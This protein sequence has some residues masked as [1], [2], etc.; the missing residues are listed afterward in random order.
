MDITLCSV[1]IDDWQV[2]SSYTLLQPHKNWLHLI[3]R[4]PSLV[5]C[6][7]IS[8]QT[9]VWKI[10]LIL[11]NNKP[12]SVSE[13]I[14]GKNKRCA[15]VNQS[16]FKIDKIFI[17]FLTFF[18]RFQR[19]QQSRGSDRELTVLCKHLKITAKKLENDFVV[20][21]RYGK[22]LIMMTW[23]SNGCDFV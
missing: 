2:H 6:S 5:V 19:R 16:I 1:M 10:S 20:Y 22:K 15:F 12:K 11:Q 13:N 18:S 4:T 3:G 7:R 17:Y 8:N 23:V 14:W 9:F 21:Y